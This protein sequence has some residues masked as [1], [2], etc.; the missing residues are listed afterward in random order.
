MVIGFRGLGKHFRNQDWVQ[1][2]EGRSQTEAAVLFEELGRGPVPGP[3]FSSGVLGA[4]TVLHGGTEE[5][6][7]ALLPQVARGERVLSLVITEPHHGWRPETVQ[8][9]ASLQ[10]GVYTLNGTKLF[11]RDAQAATHLTRST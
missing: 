9:R 5:Q 3:Y 4:L 1:C 2:G 10:G 7:H 8:M 6:K 11:V